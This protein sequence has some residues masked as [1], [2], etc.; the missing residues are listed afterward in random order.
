MVFC[1]IAVYDTDALGENVTILILIDGFLQYKLLSTTDGWIKSHNPY[2]NR[3]FSAIFHD[4][5][6]SIFKMRHNPYF[7]RW[8]S[9]IKEWQKKSLKTKCHNPYFNRWFSAMWLFPLIY[10]NKL[11]SQSLF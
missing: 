4:K 6:F 3:W 1:N 7:N 8:F 2:F 5:A 11:S 10:K 9:A